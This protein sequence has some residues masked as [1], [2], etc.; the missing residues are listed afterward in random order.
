LASK[1]K[2][3]PACHKTDVSVPY[4]NKKQTNNKQQT[5]NNKQQTTKI[6]AFK[7]ITTTNLR[8]QHGKRFG[9]GNQ[10]KECVRHENC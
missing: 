3:L 7:Q 2:V 1:H 10:G 8:I 5:T 9:W 6:F 4:P